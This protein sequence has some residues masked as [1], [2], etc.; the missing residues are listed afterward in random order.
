MAVPT[1]T[2]VTPATGSSGGRRVITITGTGFQPSPAPPAAGPVGVL[3]P[4]VAVEFDGYRAERVDVVSSQLLRVLLPPYRRGGEA[5]FADPLPVVPVRVLNID[6]TGDLIGAEQVVRTSGFQYVRV[7]KRA[8]DATE[9][10]Q[11]YRQ[12][13]R[14][15]VQTFQRQ[16]LPNTAIGTNLD[17]GDLGQIVIK[18]AQNPSCTL[19]GPRIQEDFESRH[20]WV[21][22]EDVDVAEGDDPDIRQQYWPAFVCSFE[23]DCILASDNQMELIALVQGLIETFQ[24]TPWIRIPVVFGDTNGAHHEFPLVLTRP[25]A[26]AI[27]DP[28][29]NLHTA[30]AV[31]DVREITWRYDDPVTITEAADDVE[32]TGQQVGGVAVD[33]ISS[34]PPG[35]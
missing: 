5:A 22:F 10:E 11:Q 18:A 7:E 20:H 3:A 23:F 24:R 25:P 6:P 34:V 15:V 31:F 29:S 8:P 21:D 35:D 14:E 28:G 16:L 1:I 9:A 33:V 2:S 19:I 17:Y 12:I 30:S 27:Q 32:V 13:I 26:M 4:T